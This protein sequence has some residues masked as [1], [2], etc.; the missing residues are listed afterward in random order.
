MKKFFYAAVVIKFIV[1]LKRL[2]TATLMIDH[3]V[4]NVNKIEKKNLII[5]ILF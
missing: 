2:I 5:F 1:C 4:V 3:F